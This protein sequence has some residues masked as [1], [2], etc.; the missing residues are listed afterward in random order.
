MT[1]ST[2]HHQGPTDLQMMES[3]GFC[4]PAQKRKV[5]HQQ[6]KHNAC[7]SL[8]QSF[9][10]SHFGCIEEFETFEELQL[11]LDLDKHNVKSMNQYDKI[12]QD[13][14]LKFSKVDTL[15]S[16]DARPS[17]TLVTDANQT[18]KDDEAAS[19]LQKGWALSK[20]RI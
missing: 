17:G 16:L 18:S 19:S 6:E 4:K 10:C 3:S 20:P 9:E 8:I 1:T 7:S 11:H 15:E 14:A 13:W 5:K 2:V 12:K